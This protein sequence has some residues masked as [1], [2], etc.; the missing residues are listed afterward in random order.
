VHLVD[1]QGLK[2][3]P[4]AKH[5]D[6]ANGGKEIIE[7]DTEGTGQKQR[8]EGRQSVAATLHQTSDVN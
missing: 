8:E 6:G 7:Q 5:M 2:G 1:G 4:S 3:K